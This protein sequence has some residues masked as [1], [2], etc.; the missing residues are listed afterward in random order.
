LELA[1]AD[2][3]A[4]ERRAARVG[5]AQGGLAK[6][7]PTQIAIEGLLLTHRPSEGFG[8]STPALGGEALSAGGATGSRR[9]ARGLNPSDCLESAGQAHVGNL[10]VGDLRAALGGGDHDSAGAVEQA[11]PSGVTVAML[12]TRPAGDEEGHVTLALQ[13]CAHIG[14]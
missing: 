11:H 6:V 1:Q 8:A 4:S 13:R 2:L 5:A 7:G 9:Y 10:E 14:S 3:K 12:P